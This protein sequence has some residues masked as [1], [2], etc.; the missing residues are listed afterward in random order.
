M[1]LSEI[2]IKSKKT[3]LCISENK[4]FYFFVSSFT[5]DKDENLD[6]TQENTLNICN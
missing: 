2:P 1:Y 6:E 4:L 3:L 5:R